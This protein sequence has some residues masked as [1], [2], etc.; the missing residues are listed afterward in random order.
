MVR[1]KA[2]V[3]RSKVTML[4]AKVC[5]ICGLDSVVY[6]V[7]DNAPVCENCVPT[8][9]INQIPNEKSMIKKILKNDSQKTM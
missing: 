1:Q 7:I 2:E 9:K 6:Q 4:P 5:N 8:Q 3:R